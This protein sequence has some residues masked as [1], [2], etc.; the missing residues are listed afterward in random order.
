MMVEGFITSARNGLIRIKSFSGVK[1]TFKSDKDYSSGQPVKFGVS[2][3]GVVVY[4]STAPSMDT[5]PEMD[6][7]NTDGGHIEKAI[8]DEQQVPYRQIGEGKS[9]EERAIEHERRLPPEAGGCGSKRC[10]SID[11]GRRGS[12]Y[13]QEAGETGQETARYQSSW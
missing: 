4:I 2:D 3:S 12:R 9:Q 10:C 5:N 11:E 8:T 13:A 7:A 1:Y 6:N